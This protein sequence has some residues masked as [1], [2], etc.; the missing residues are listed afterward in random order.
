MGSLEQWVQ[1][2]GDWEERERDIRKKGGS[3]EG[4]QEEK[5]RKM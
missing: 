2:A 3:Q 4:K 1:S 5:G